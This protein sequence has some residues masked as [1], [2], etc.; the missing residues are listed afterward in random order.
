MNAGVST[1]REASGKEMIAVPVLRSILLVDLS[2]GLYARVT[3]APRAGTPPRSYESLVVNRSNV[4][5]ESI[6]RILFPPFSSLSSLF[7]PLSRFL[8]LLRQSASAN[9]FLLFLA[10]YTCQRSSHGA[11]RRCVPRNRALPLESG[12]HPSWTFDCRGTCQILAPAKG[13]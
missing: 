2:V 1:D 3:F 8:S 9:V 7:L 12:S 6:N 13:D 4:M 5:R 10:S 11:M